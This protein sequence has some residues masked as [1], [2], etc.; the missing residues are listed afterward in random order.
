MQDLL[1]LFMIFVID[2]YVADMISIVSHAKVG[3][4]FTLRIKNEVFEAI[5]RQVKLPSPSVSSYR[6][7]PPHT[8]S[9]SHLLSLSIA[10]AGHRLLCQE[11]RGRRS[12]PPAG[13]L[14]AGGAQLP[15][16]AAIHL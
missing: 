10:S 15:R 5:M 4:A 8:A 1:C 13:R 6:Y 11:R 7:P 2:W 3:S 12:E 9:F 14:R 16:G